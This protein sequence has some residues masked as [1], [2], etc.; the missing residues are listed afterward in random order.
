[1]LHHVGH[2][3]TGRMPPDDGRCAMLHYRL[4]HG[5]GAAFIILMLLIAAFTDWGY[6]AGP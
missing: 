1:M 6:Y 5:L 2:V 4:W 3:L